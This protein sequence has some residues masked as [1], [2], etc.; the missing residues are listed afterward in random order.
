MCAH[1][2]IIIISAA[3][4]NWLPTTPKTTVNMTTCFVNR[5]FWIFSKWTYFW[6]KA[7]IHE[8]T[9]INECFE[10]SLEISAKNVQK[11]WEF[12][13]K[14]RIRQKLKNHGKRRNSWKKEKFHEKSTMYRN[15]LYQRKIDVKI[16]VFMKIRCIHELII[17]YSMETLGPALGLNKK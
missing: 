15:S 6:M 3:T 16:G 5:L 7:P 2:K 1:L 14:L 8:T 10:N 11:N 13:E 12:V 9:E 4:F 17:Q